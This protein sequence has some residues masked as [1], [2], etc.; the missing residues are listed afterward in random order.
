V[1]LGRI[2]NVQVPKFLN[3]NSGY[4]NCSEFHRYYGIMQPPKFMYYKRVP[5]QTVL[6]MGVFEGSTL[7]NRLVAIVKGVGS[8]SSASCH[9]SSQ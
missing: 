8:L 9:V 6:G 5:M 4:Y 1:I 3:A 7:I 2:F